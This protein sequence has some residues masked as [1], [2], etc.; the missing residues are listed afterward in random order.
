MCYSV[1]TTLPMMLNFLLKPFNLGN[2]VYSSILSIM[3]LPGAVIGCV[4]T[5][6]YLKR[7]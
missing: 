5:S 4:L 7:Y 2:P 6:I 1:L 3:P